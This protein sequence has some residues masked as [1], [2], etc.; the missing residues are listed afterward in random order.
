M[1][2][3]LI[4]ICIIAVF[5]EIGGLVQSG[6]G[7]KPSATVTALLEPPPRTLESPRTNGYFLLLGFT[8]TMFL[9]PVETG[10]AMWSEA[11]LDRSH[12]VF[13]YDKEARSGL[14][15][16]PDT[17]QALQAWVSPDPMAGF[18][19]QKGFV[20]KSVTQ[21]AILIDRYQQWLAM[22]FED[23]GYGHVGTPRFTDLLVAHRLFVAEGFSRNVAIGVDRLEKDLS[24]W[25][26]VLANA[27][28]LP[29][30]MMAAVMIDDDVI[31]MSKVLS[32]RRLSQAMVWRLT[33]LTRPLEQAERSMRWPIQH[34]FIVGMNRDKWLFHSVAATGL[35][36]SK[37]NKQWIAIRAGLNPDAFEKVG[38]PFSTKAL[39]VSLET[40]GTVNAYATYYDAVIKAADIPHSPLPKLQE[41]V[42]TSPRTFV[43][44]LVNPIRE[45]PAWEPFLQRIMETD[46]RLRL[47]ALQVKLRKPSRQQDLPARIAQAG[48]NYFDPFTDLPM[49]WSSTQGKLYSVGKDGLDD[50]GD[51]TFDI[52][53]PTVF[54]S[55]IPSVPSKAV[56]AKSTVRRR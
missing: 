21:Y 39:G 27:K 31:L 19:I 29:T 16:T 10:Y 4:T 24:V 30:K 5:I 8:A 9:D 3:L 25:R 17:V 1:R 50:G 12:R 18:Q 54:A 46:A 43:D 38:Q 47:V 41:M 35:E 28:T 11:E 32:Q 13:N 37:A 26:M 2:K 34:E 23:W 49:L 45:E 15:V 7:G 56:K 40:Q 33:G 52:S 55:N 36:E 51:S 6:I 14:R 22:P 42:R 53:V 44:R 20:K 48:T